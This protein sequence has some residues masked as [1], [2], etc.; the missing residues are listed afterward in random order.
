[1]ARSCSIALSSFRKSLNLPGDRGTLRHGG[2]EY[3]VKAAKWA[4]PNRSQVIHIVAGDTGS[5]KIGDDVMASIDWEL[6]YLRMR[7]HTAFIWWHPSCHTQLSAGSFTMGMGIRIFRSS[8]AAC[9]GMTLKALSP[10]WSAAPFRSGR[11]GIRATLWK[12]GDN[13]ALSGRE[14]TIGQIACVPSRLAISSRSLATA[15]TS[16]IRLKLAA[17]K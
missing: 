5:F 3:L 8:R 13:C 6:R 9:S 11:L 16:G 4:E 12:D 1:M 2:R 7:A 14:R 10:F 17:S 15:S